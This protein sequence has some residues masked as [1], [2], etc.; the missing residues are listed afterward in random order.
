MLNLITLWRKIPVTIPI[1]VA[2]VMCNAK[3]TA[4][5]VEPTICAATSKVKEYWGPPVMSNKTLGKCMVNPPMIEP[6]VMKNTSFLMEKLTRGLYRDS[7]DCI[8]PYPS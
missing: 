8:K 7:F 2:T 6:I 5:I 4:G 3:P 1:I